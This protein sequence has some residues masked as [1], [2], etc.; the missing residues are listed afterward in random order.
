MSDAS[1]EY[2]G[3]ETDRIRARIHN[4]ADKVQGHEVFLEQHRSDLAR[5]R[6]DI[7]ELRQQTTQY[8]TQSQLVSEKTL[9]MNKLDT[10]AGDVA[11]IRKAGYW[12]MGVVGTAIVLAI[13]NLILKG[14]GPQ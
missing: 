12:F 7:R 6:D 14:G 13:M 3:T 1:N 9:L 5:N 10:I 8:V 2:T 11:G 4:L